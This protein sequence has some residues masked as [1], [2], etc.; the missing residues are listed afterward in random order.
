ML[1]FETGFAGGIRQRFYLAVVSRPAAVEHHLFD[2][3][4]AGG[5]SGELAHAFGAG[6]VSGQ[7]FFPRGGLGPAGRGGEGAP[8]LVIDELHVD[9]LAGEAD[10]HAGP[11]GGALNLFADTPVPAGGE[12]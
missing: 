7:G 10:T 3:L 11:G 6:H 1:E 9:V 4:G 5:L 12:S 2:A 8:L